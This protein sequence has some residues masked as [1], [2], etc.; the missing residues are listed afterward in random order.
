VIDKDFNG[1]VRI[2]DI[3]RGL[4]CFAAY[5]HEA[6]RR[7]CDASQITFASAA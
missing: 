2:K 7:P 4:G 3:M 6:H 1:R 5:L